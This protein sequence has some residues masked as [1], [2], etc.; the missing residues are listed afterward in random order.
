MPSGWVIELQFAD[1]LEELMRDELWELGEQLRENEV[2]E[3]AE[4]K[5]VETCGDEGASD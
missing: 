3:E 4:K 1:E 5:S 2:T